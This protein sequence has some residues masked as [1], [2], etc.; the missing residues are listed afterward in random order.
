MQDKC[1]LSKLKKSKTKRVNSR[2]KGSNFQ[3][4]IAKKLNEIFGTKDFCPTPGSGAFAT[5]HDLPE[6]L[7]IYGDLITPKNF[8]FVI[9]CK[10]GY[11]DIRI[12]DLFK[13]NKG[14]WEFIDQVKRDSGKANKEWMVIFKQKRSDI[15]MITAEG[16]LPEIEPN[17]S[18]NKVSINLFSTINNIPISYLFE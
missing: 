17:F 12:T 13:F 1:N 3:R 6:H 4:D 2:R 16:V 18:G 15:L 10:C 9:E 14:I 7:Q 11:D 8:R 5:T